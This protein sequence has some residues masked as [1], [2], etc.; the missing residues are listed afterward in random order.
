MDNC[1][2]DYNPGLE[3]VNFGYSLNLRKMESL[4]VGRQQKASCE[5]KNACLQLYLKTTE[6]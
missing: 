3:E 6:E 2:G 4:L 1:G 5:W